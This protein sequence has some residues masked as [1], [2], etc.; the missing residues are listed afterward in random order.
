M[1]FQ[2]PPNEADQSVPVCHEDFST[3]LSAH[4][5]EFFLCSFLEIIYPGEKEIYRK[6][7][8]NNETM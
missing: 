1:E 5:N 7:E 4:D 8:F 6:N 2:D 3:F